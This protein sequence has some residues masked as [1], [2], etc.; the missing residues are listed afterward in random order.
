MT[1]NLFI[2]VLSFA[3]AL[4]FLTSALPG[5][6][7]GDG[8][9]KQGFSLSMQASIDPYAIFAE[10]SA[11]LIDLQKFLE[12]IT[13]TAEGA[14]EGEA[15]AVDVAL[16]YKGKPAIDANFSGTIE[17][18]VATT[19]LL[20]NMPVLL[21]MASYVPNALRID[22][23]LS[24]PI[25]YLAV[26]TDPFSYTYGLVPVIQDT[27]ALL[28]FTQSKQYTTAEAVA[29]AE[30][31]RDT[32]ENRE[33]FLNWMQGLLN[34]T[35]LYY[36][37]ANYWLD[38][39]PEWVEYVAGDKG[40]T[41]TIDENGHHWRIGDEDVFHYDNTESGGR[42]SLSFPMLEGSEGLNNLLL[43]GNL[44]K[45]DT[46]YDCEGSITVQTLDWS[47]NMEDDSFAHLDFQLTGWPLP[48]AESGDMN[49]RL[50]LTGNAIHIEKT[51]DV[52]LAWVK[53][54]Q[55]EKEVYS[56][57]FHINKPNRKEPMLT[58]RGTIELMPTEIEILQYDKAYLDSLHNVFTLG[59]ITIGPFVNDALKP[60][61]FAIAPLVLRLP[62]SIT[63][64]I[65]EWAMEGG[66]LNM[67]S[68]SSET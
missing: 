55:G 23:M 12:Q 41:V 26:A 38:Y 21:E 43:S 39:L 24:L 56:G 25:Q 66:L 60:A 54:Q 59:D 28:G 9:E 27:K 10:P 37:F 2:R 1:R 13:F 22:S 67:V 57:E 47:G 40:M 58:L 44:S 19:N 33:P 16:G 63:N 14:V 11:L 31:F 4:V 32:V 17:L 65:I 61:V 36:D 20:G 3:C 64:H 49:M 5:A 62:W 53:E 42:F 52:S 15:L 8:A 46:G 35:G 34:E 7:K 48:D 68:F 50:T 18:I 6:A 29:L 45:G 30:T 51:F